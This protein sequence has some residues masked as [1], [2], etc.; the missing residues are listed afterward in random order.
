MSAKTAAHNLNLAADDPARRVM[1]S[2][3]MRRGLLSL[4]ELFRLSRMYDEQYLADVTRRAESKQTEIL[5][6]RPV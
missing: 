4:W 1:T 2:T 5:Q 3:L 6:R